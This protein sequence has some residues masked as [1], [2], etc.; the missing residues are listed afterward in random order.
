MEG[1][2]NDITREARVRRSHAGD[3]ERQAVAD[4]SGARVDWV[5][6]EENGPSADEPADI[7]RGPVRRRDP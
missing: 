1:R 6:A 4:R 3:G 5:G 2:L 7:V